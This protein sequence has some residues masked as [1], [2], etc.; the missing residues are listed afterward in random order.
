MLKGE[1]M[2]SEKDQV[3]I[4]ETQ[5]GGL[6]DRSCSRL[7]P[8]DYIGDYFSMGGIDLSKTEVKERLD[9]AMK[10]AK[11]TRPFNPITFKNNHKEKLSRPNKSRYLELSNRDIYDVD[12]NTIISR[13]ALQALLVG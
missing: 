5:G 1:R 4:D 13:K 11:T 3:F 9:R 2:C 8:W 6:V 12:S 7:M 10:T